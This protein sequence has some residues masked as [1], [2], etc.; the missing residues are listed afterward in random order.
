MADII[1]TAVF[2]QHFFRGIDAVK[3]KL[4]RMLS[5]G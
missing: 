2:F 4:L 3:P 5:N 1:H